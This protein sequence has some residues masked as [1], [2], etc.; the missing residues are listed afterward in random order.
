MSNNVIENLELNIQIHTIY[1]SMM[2]IKQSAEY[3]YKNLEQMLENLNN[4]NKILYDKIDET[5]QNEIIP[6]ING[7]ESLSRLI[8]QYHDLYGEAVKKAA[9]YESEIAQVYLDM[10]ND[11]QYDLSKF[12]ND[13]EN[14]NQRLSNDVLSED[15]IDYG[16]YF[17]EL[18]ELL[19]K[20]S[21]R[22]VQSSLLNYAQQIADQV[23]STILQQN[24]VIASSIDLI[25]VVLSEVK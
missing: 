2:M 8:N 9:N 1:G 25:D 14:I 12:K 7:F 19:H 5:H 17:D 22:D 10:S 13:Y 4:F 6:V 18:V 11:E 23:F 20:I 21:N 3:R 24:E 16:K 15:F